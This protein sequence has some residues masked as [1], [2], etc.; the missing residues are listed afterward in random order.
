MDGRENNRGTIG[1][2]GGNPGAGKL[3]FVRQQVEKYALKWWN[4]W[5]VAIDSDDK[6]ERQ[7]AMTEYNKLQCKMIPQDVKQSGVVKIIIANEADEPTDDSPNEDT[8][9]HA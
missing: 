7:F 4:N 3:N 9:G 2:K 6:Q 8:E 1:N 5:E